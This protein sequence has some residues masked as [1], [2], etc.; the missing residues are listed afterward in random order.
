MDANISKHICKHIYCL[1][2]T[3]FNK[4]ESN[5][6][7]FSLHIYVVTI[8]ISKPKYAKICHLKD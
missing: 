1:T 2:D 8:L 6:L 7:Q 5:N 3:L 4:S